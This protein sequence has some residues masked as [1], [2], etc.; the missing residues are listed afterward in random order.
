[1]INKQGVQ[2]NLTKFL[3]DQSLKDNKTGCFRYFEKVSIYVQSIKEIITEF[4][5][6]FNKVHSYT[7]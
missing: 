7:K 6:Y 2:D 5:R 3:H 1:M 4:Y